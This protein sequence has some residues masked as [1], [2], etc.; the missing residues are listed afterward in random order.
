MLATKK[1][2]E[3]NREELWALLSFT[4]DGEQYSVVHARVNGS[5]KLEMAAA[6]GKRSVECVAKS[7]GAVPFEVAIDA[8]FLTKCK[9]AIDGKHGE[10]LLI[11]LTSSGVKDALIIDKESGKTIAPIGWNRESSTTQ[12][13]MASIVSGLRVP[14]DANHTGSW[15]AIDPDHL[16]GLARVRVATDGCPVTIYPPSDPTAPL[17]FE[18]R[19]EGGHWKGAI[20]P[21]AVIAPGGEAEEAPDE[22]EDAPGRRNKNWQLD[23]ADQLKANRAK[24]EAKAAVARVMADD[25]DDEEDGGAVIDDEEAE[26]LKSEQGGKAPEKKPR[27]VQKRKKAGS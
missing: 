6:D 19:S 26:R 11:R 21:E 12:V 20:T 4:G 27:K 9:D 5:A 8:A 17:H 7:D 24:E 16:R 2:I 10:S 15:C 25:D 14:S 18:C 23:I 22:D 1:G 13:T 3:I